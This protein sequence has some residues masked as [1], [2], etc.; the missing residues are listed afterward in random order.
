MA[1]TRKKQA[2]PASGYQQ[3]LSDLKGHN[4]SNLNIFFGEEKYL[5]YWC[6]NNLK[7]Q[8]VEGLA[9]DFNY[10]RFDADTFTIATFQDAVEAPP[11]MSDKTL[12]EL[13]DINLFDPTYDKN[14]L[15]DIF[16]DIPDYCCILVLFDTI[17]WKPDKRQKK[18]W[19]AISDHG[20]IYE[21]TEQSEPDLIKWIQKRCRLDNIEITKEAASHLIQRAGS[22][23]QNLASETEKLISY[24]QTGCITETD[25]DDAVIPILSSAI[26]MITDALSRGDFNRAIVTLQNVL[27]QDIEPVRI[28]ASISSQMRQLYV[29]KLLAENGKG[30]Y[31]LAKLYGIYERRANNVYSQARAFKRAQLQQAV[32][33]CTDTDMQLKSFNGDDEAILKDLMIALAEL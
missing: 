20:T 7:K 32:R 18:L 3:F 26:Y 19:S 11:M 10:H 21:F 15:S 9:A 4:Y 12:V 14:Q 8:L 2:Q 24:T 1:T 25:I 33:L 13:C 17:E 23:M 6:R 29:A 28:S 16:A 30:S 22:S 27:A 31:D 5:L